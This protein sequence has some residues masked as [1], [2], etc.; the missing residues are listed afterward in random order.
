M[1]ILEGVKSES[2]RAAYNEP[3]QQCFTA[4]TIDFVD[5]DENC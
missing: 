1:G 3:K 2:L 5:N 4:D